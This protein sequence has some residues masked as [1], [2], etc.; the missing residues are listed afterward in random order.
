MSA[1]YD[2]NLEEEDDEEYEANGEGEEDEDIEE[3]E[4]EE[5]AESKAGIYYVIFTPYSSRRS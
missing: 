4:E 5:V 2:S 1:I 3:E